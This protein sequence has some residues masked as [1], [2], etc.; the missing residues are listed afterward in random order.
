M[1]NDVYLLA[2]LARFKTF[3]DLNRSKFRNVRAVLPGDFLSP[4]TLSAID[5]GRGMVDVL[6]HT[7]LDYACIGNH[8]GD[9]AYPHLIKR[10]EESN[11]KWVNSNMRG[12]KYPPNASACQL[13]EFAIVNV[14]G[15]HKTRK[16]ALLGIATDDMSEYKPNPLGGC[17]IDS[18]V[19]TALALAERLADE[20]DLIVPMT[21]LRVPQDEQLCALG[22]FPI[23]LGG[24]DHFVVDRVVNGCRI[25]KCGHDAERFGIIDIRWD[26]AGHPTAETSL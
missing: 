4:S 8:E 9:I 21:H 2:N 20:V 13:P 11:F 22:R 19:A 15:A 26:D 23:L 1:I 5:H 6:N 18:P 14:E 12:F 24:H 17:R 16:V 25:L 10:I 3:V 7:G